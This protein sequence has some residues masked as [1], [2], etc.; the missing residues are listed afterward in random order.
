MTFVRV[1]VKNKTCG[2]V[3]FCLFYF[4]GTDCKSALSGLILFSILLSLFT[5]CKTD[6]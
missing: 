6:D 1:V 4:M 3:G 5:L 2:G